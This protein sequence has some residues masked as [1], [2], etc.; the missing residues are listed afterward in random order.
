MMVLYHN[1][2]AVWKARKALCDDYC[3][4]C[5]NYQG[6]TTTNLDI[7]ALSDSANFIEG[8]SIKFIAGLC[9]LSLNLVHLAFKF[10]IIFQKQ[11]CETARIL[12]T[13]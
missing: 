9:I 3:N 10:W 11:D 5:E 8:Y 12:V 1:P 4:L 2:A 13:F 6:Y 7:S